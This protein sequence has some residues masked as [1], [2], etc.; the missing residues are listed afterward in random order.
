MPSGGVRELRFLSLH[1][2]MSFHVIIC[3]RDQNEE[4]RTPMK[5]F[6]CGSLVP[7]CDWHTRHE[8]EAEIMRRVVQH[9]RETHGETVIRETMIEAIR[10]RIEKVPDAA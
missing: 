3:P 7:G 4:G 9:M 2:V 8:E 5:E 6:Q 10:S 1:P